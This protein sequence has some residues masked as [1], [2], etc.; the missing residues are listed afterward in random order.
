MSV[1][2]GIGHLLHLSRDVAISVKGAL[3]ELK[4]AAWGFQAIHN[5]LYLKYMQ[6]IYTWSKIWIRNKKDCNC[7]I[8]YCKSC[9]VIIKAPGC[10][11]LQQMMRGDNACKCYSRFLS[12]LSQWFNSYLMRG[13]FWEGEWQISLTGDTASDE[14]TLIIPHRELQ[15]CWSKDCHNMLR[16][17][18]S[19][20]RVWH[21]W[22]WSALIY[23]YYTVCLSNG[24]EDV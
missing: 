16:S 24:S 20:E 18:D 15:I 9:I 11:S 4:W 5:W 3:Q 19:S 6:I 1:L 23:G 13:Q 14:S 22:S 8:I 21:I 7:L 12:L 2:G 10:D 17:R